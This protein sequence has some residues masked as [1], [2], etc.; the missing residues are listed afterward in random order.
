MKLT[1]SVFLL[2]FVVTFLCCKKEQSRQEEGSEK[3]RDIEV[4]EPHFIADG[5]VNLAVRVNSV[6]SDNTYDFGIV[7]SKDISF[8]QIV[9]FHRFENPIQVKT[10]QTEVRSGLEIDSV[11]YYSYMRDGRVSIL[12]EDVFEFKF[13]KEGAMVIDSISASE[14]AVGDTIKL[15]G[16]F[17]GFQIT[18]GG[19]G[20]VELR[21]FRRSD[22]IVHL[23]LD[24][25]TPTGPQRVFLK[26]TYQRTVFP[27]AFQLVKPVITSVPE[28]ILIEE[29]VTIEGENFS[30]YRNRNKI[31]LNDVEV[32]IKS[33]RENKLTFI[34]PKTISSATLHLKVAANNDTV[35][36]QKPMRIKR[37]VLNSALK[38]LTIQKSF[39]L[40]FD[41]LPKTG[42][43]ILF[44]G[45]EAS[46][47]HRYEQQGKDYLTLASMIHP[48]TSKSIK[49]EI[50]YLDEKFT[51]A[52]NVKILDRWSVASS[53]IPFHVFGI[54]D[55]AVVV[56]NTAYVLGLPS[57]N[58]WDGKFS[59]WK[60][61]K[62]SAT[63]SEIP[64]SMLMRSPHMTSH[65]GKIYFYTG[66]AGDNFYQFNPNDN[67]F[68]KLANYP[69]KQRLEGTMR[70]INGKIYLVTGHNPGP[71]PFSNSEPDVTMYIYDI[72]NNSWSKSVDFPEN[73]GF[74]YNGRLGAT[75]FV[76]QNKMYVMGGPHHTGQVKTYSFD[77]ATNQWK[78]HA[79][80][81][82]F[83]RKS[84]I[85]IGN[86]G[87][88]FQNGIVRYDP[89]RD[90]WETLE[91]VVPY[92][93]ITEHTI[94]FVIDNELYYNV[95][96]LD[97]LFKIS[98]AELTR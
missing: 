41:N 33:Y 77:P 37:P 58:I 15:H 5:G 64:I 87:Y 90:V 13:G 81:F 32:D 14:A 98:T 69:A 50:S 3:K 97:N 67:T 61:N 25:K 12:Q 59:L 10:Y 62:S 8:R 92:A 60:F 45:F 68:K 72:D 36:Y 55:P 40:E 24:E 85:A 54:A 89:N 57:V 48:F 4:L 93:S 44:G 16:N 73:G 91:Y 75:S 83:G 53:K 82:D 76:L 26:S 20:D 51:I 31:Y 28:E 80:I 29:E 11:Y 46:T 38:E 21:T 70:A 79:D 52:E 47:I 71:N 18:G 86:Y 6:P 1:K 66:D 39:S 56:N 96:N 42:V 88:F 63:F 22:N 65:N 95:N 49:C 30:K 34:I 17:K 84:S 2:C 23:I 9:S 35:A 94:A 7:I 74:A 19:I 27:E 43:K 78:T